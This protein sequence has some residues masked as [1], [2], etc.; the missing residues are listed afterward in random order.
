MPFLTNACAF[1]IIC[2]K[3]DVPLIRIDD[4]LFGRAIITTHGTITIEHGGAEILLA[5]GGPMYHAGSTC[6][7]TH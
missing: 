3:T 7:A 6:S 2:F 1:L 5:T 4:E